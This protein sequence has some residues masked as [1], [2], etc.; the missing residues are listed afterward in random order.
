MP[1]ST[2]LHNGCRHYRG[3]HDCEGTCTA[4]IPKWLQLW[5]PADIQE[6]YKNEID[7]YKDA[8]DCEMYE[9]KVESPLEEKV[10]SA[11][12]NAVISAMETEL[13]CLERRGQDPG[14]VPSYG[15]DLLRMWI[16]TLSRNSRLP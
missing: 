16:A 1:G 7:G 5:C 4:P 15:P 10:Q 14:L 3:D 11:A 13:E 6:R 12:I 9:P 8:G 2:K